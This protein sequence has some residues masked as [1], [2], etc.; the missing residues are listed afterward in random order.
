[1]IPIVVTMNTI[2]ANGLASFFAAT[3]LPEAVQFC[4]GEFITDVQKFVKIQLIRAQRPGKT[5]QIAQ[6]KLEQLKIVLSKMGI[7]EE[8]N[9]N[10]LKIVR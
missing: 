5:A 3:E 2:N 7:T 8:Y 1:M 4:K 6:N 10:H 9:Y